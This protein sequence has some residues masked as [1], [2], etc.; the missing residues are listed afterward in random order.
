MY[1]DGNWESRIS[2]MIAFE[3]L[4]FTMDRHKVISQ[5]IYLVRFLVGTIDDLKLLITEKVI[6]LESSEIETVFENLLKV[7][8]LLESIYASE[9]M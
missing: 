5:L 2:N 1:I 6:V 7:S 4:Y 3:D 9:N 8:K